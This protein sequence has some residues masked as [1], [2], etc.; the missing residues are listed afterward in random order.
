MRL[1]ELRRAYRVGSLGRE[2]LMADPLDMLAAWVR[3]AE[4]AGEVEPNAL[5]LASVAADGR[6]SVRYVLLKE[7]SPAGL[8]FFT[9]YESRKAHE[10]DGAGVAAAALWWPLLERQVR[11]EGRVERVPRAVSEA[12]FAT[13]PRGSQLGAW[14][15]P[16]S[17]PLEDRGEL[18][19]RA[20]AVTARFAG[21]D[22]PCPPHW[23]GYLLRP[24][25]VEF[26]QGRDDRLHD[27]FLYTREGDAWGITRLAP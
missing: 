1:D 26:W 15:S 8:T 19:A 2:E 25:R 16:Q 11:A 6:P 5:A 23:G 21:G 18:E 17:S 3:R 9:N 7:V 27:R 20:A 10:L 12:Y 4:E 24:E 22:V 13:R 14:T